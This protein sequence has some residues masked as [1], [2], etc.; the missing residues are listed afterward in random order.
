MRDYLA[1][2]RELLPEGPPIFVAALGPL[3]VRVAAELA[4]GVALNWCSAPQVSSSRERVEAAAG[5]AGRPVPVIAEY[6]RTAVDPDRDAA[7]RALGAAMLPYLGVP[8]YRRH[9][10]RM[11]FTEE[12]ARLEGG[13]PADALLDEAGAAGR[14]GEVGPKFEALARDLDIPIVRVLVAEP[15]DAAS[16]ERVLRECAP[17]G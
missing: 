11:G 4:D 12:V 10:E 8:W 14:P 9:F 16:A 3:M 5:A 13:E 1:R 7:R 15:G 2:L 17:G 6:I